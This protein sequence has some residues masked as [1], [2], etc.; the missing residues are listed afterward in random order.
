MNVG[1]RIEVLGTDTVTGN[2]Y[3][4]LFATVYLSEYG[5]QLFDIMSC[6]VMSCHVMSYTCHARKGTPDSASQRGYTTDITLSQR[7]GLG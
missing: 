6:H 5:S 2:L 1:R 3:P 7:Q 4:S